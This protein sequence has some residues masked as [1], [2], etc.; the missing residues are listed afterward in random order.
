M[1]HPL[2]LLLMM[3]YAPARAMSEV[4]DR[5]PLAQAALIAAVTQTLFALCVYWQEL[6]SAGSGQRVL[7]LIGAVFLQSAL[8]LLIVALAFA[9]VVVF[10]ANLFE[11]RGSFGVVLRQEYAATLSALLYGWAAANLAALPFAILARASDLHMAY[12]QEAFRSYRDIVTILESNGQTVTAAITDPKVFVQAFFSLLK[13]PF[14]VVWA[15]IVVRELFRFSWLRAI[16]TVL[17]SGF[18]ASV[19]IAPLFE[20]V[21]RT[22][23]AFPILL[24][25]LFFIMRGYFN[26]VMSAQRARAAFKQNLQAA[27][28]NPA[29]ASAHYNLGLIHLQRKEYGEARARFERAVETDAEETDAHYQLGRISRIEQRY[30]DAI[31][32]FGAVVERD[33]THTQHEI[34]REVGATYLAAG[35]DEDAR[36][37]LERFLE[38]R[39]S[40]PEALYLMGRALAG[41]GRGRE[42]IERLRAC[43]EAVKSAPAYKYR[44]EKRWLNE[45]QQFLRTL[46]A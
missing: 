15:T 32:H 14:L 1:V 3:F 22:L 31:K 24:L 25:F 44:T 37:A 4:R 45:A 12:A 23:F 43:I 26:D 46:E 30:A 27:T 10:V 5:A 17:L 6:A 20:F 13:I 42:A 39:E 29:D 19:F 41:L 11:R 33:P 2:R 38:K 7:F 18:L 40:D 9:P 35:Q 21:F 8:S 36:D 34:W 28:L 16:W